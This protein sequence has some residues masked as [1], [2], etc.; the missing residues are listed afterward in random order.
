MRC[1]DFLKAKKICLLLLI[2]LLG[3]F[4][5]HFYAEETV[6]ADP[7]FR[8]PLN[9]ILSPVFSYYY[10]NDVSSNTKN[11]YCGADKVYNGH[12]GTDFRA[13]VG[14]SIYAGASGGLYYRYDNCPT[15]GYLGSTCGGGYGNHARIDHEGNTND[16]VGWITIYA[17]MQLGTVGWH[18]SLLC[19]AYIGAT[20]SS[21]NSSGPH[22]HFEVRKYSYPNNDPFSGSCSGPVSFWVNQNNGVPATQCQ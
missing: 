20:G 7:K 4:T 2:I 3:F 19:G 12:Q 10:D 21:G 15:Y 18:Q 16:G 1:N 9:T 11:Y 5:L 17:H 22:L 6:A 14:T 13:V 8:R